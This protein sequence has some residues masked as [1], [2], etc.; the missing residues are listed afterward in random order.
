MVVQ[1]EMSVSK[2]Y[3][4]KIGVIGRLSRG[5]ERRGWLTDVCVRTVEEGCYQHTMLNKT[6]RVRRSRWGQKPRIASP[7]GDRT[8]VFTVST[9]HDVALQMDSEPLT[10]PFATTLSPIPRF[11]SHGYSRWRFIHVSELHKIQIHKFCFKK[12]GTE[13]QYGNAG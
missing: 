11:I 6:R 10:H 8:K 9:R 4:L 2:L 12:K 1:N 5:E 13:R 3:I 7:P